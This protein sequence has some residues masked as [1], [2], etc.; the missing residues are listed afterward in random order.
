M[1]ARLTRQ[2][3]TRHY[4]AQRAT[5]GMART[6]ATTTLR[7]WRLPI[8]EDDAALVVSELATNAVRMSKPTDQIILHLRWVGTGLLIGVWDSSTKMPTVNT[9]AE[10]TLDDIAP[11]PDALE[12]DDDRAGGRGLPLVQTLAT[13]LQV[14]RT[15]SPIGKWVVALLPAMTIAMQDEHDGA[16]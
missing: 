7:K 1:P 8:S 11:D 10:L 6:Q 3:N 16:A 15:H 5:V 13:A 9:I 14:E 12:H 4:S 2:A